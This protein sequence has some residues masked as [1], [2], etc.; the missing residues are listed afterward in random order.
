MMTTRPLILSI[1]CIALLI[2]LSF[3]LSPYHLNHLTSVMVLAC[4][5]MGYNLLFGYTGLLS[6]GQA[7]FFAA[8]LYG[9]GLSI[10]LWD[11]SYALAVTIGI[12]AAF[13]GSVLIGLLALR[14]RGVAFMIVTLMLAQA[15]YSSIFYFN[16]ITRGDEG[17]VIPRQVLA[18]LDL[19]HPSHRYFIALALLTVCLYLTLFI[20]QTSLGRI[21]KA[22]RDNEERV[23]MLGYP[24]E[25]Y[26]LIAFVLAGTFSGAAGVAQGLISGYI[27]ASLASVH[28]SIMPLLWVLLGGAGTVFGPLDWHIMHVLSY[29]NIEQPNTCLY[30][31][32][33]HRIGDAAPFCAAWDRW[34]DSTKISSMAPLMPPSVLVSFIP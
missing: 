7:M 12:S 1:A 8:G 29:R 32:C 21:L 14:T 13:L 17:F 34:R 30:A 28:Y 4:H 25:R 18:G 9:L 3:S 20:A 10:H 24:V 19:S 26:K 2:L 27:G 6:L 5:A 11:F 16:R 23:R 15:A 22:I 33:R 31:Y